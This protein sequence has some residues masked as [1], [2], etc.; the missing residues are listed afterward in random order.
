MLAPN[1][2]AADFLKALQGLLPRGRIWP[3]ADDAVQ[4]QVLSGLAPSYERQTAR[5]NYLLVDAFPGTAYELL[6]EWEETLGLPDP[7]AGESPTISNR[8]AQVVMRLANNG[9]Q[10]IAFYYGQAALI[11]CSIIIEQQAPFGMGSSG[12]GDPMGGSEWAHVWTVWIPFNDTPGAAQYW[13]NAVLECEFETLAPAHTVVQFADSAV[14]YW[15]LDPNG[16]SLLDQIV[17]VQ[18]P[19]A[20]QSL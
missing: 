15:M 8:Q 11:G 7:C 6:P 20:L 1:F 16:A 19:S 18:L 12:M 4:T 3:R 2:T 9:G 5:A 10:S 17:N 14:L 13:G